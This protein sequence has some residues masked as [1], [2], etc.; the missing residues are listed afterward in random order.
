MTTVV[1]LNRVRKQR[2]R[3]DAL[4]RAAE[5]R[6]A[7]GRRKD[8]RQTMERERRRADRDLDGKRLD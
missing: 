1:N 8:E 7:F 4:R 3:A 2:Q 5:N 6:V